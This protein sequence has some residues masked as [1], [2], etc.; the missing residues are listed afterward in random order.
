MHT[1]YLN[2]SDIERSKH[3]TIQRSH[4]IDLKL[5]AEN[6]TKK[7]LLTVGAVSITSETPNQYHVIV[8]DCIDGAIFYK[9]NQYT[10]GKQ[11]PRQVYEKEQEGF[12]L[13]GIKKL[14]NLS[15]T[16]SFTFSTPESLLGFTCN[17]YDYEVCKLNKQQKRDYPKGTTLCII[18][19]NKVIAYIEE[20][21]SWE[22]PN[23]LKSADAYTKIIFNSKSDYDKH[24]LAGL[25]FLCHLAEYWANM[26]S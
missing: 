6:A 21:G 11:A 12:L 17:G 18:A 22:V 14:L 19:R 13:K 5:I 1:L 20:K 9:Q 3:G 23:L 26:E 7:Q 16:P 4:D 15:D 10:I 8:E 24:Q 2:N 25:I